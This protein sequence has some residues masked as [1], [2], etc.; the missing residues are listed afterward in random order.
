MPNLKKLFSKAEK[1]DKVENLS[2]CEKDVI[3]D[4]KDTLQVCRIF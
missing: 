4:K 1:K 3:F 2:H